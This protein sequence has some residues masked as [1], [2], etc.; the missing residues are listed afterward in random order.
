MRIT[1][2][3]GIL[4]A[5]GWI[6]IKLSLFGMGM[7]SE[8]SLKPAILLNMLFLILAITVGLFLQKRKDSEDGNALRDIKNGMTAGVPYAIIVSVFIYFYYSKIDPEYIQSKL[9]DTEIEL[10]KSMEDPIKFKTLKDSN[11]DFEVM[12]D[13][14]I[15]KSVIK[16]S[17]GVYN[18]KSTAITSLLAMT[19]YATL[20][21]IFITII[22][23]KIVFRR[24]N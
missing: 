8:D 7:N 10:K 12:T 14:Q 19:L 13:K 24:K 16:N 18:A 5:F 21:S 1:L 15:I 22:L 20:N 3:S 4:F 11:P 9:A 17:K 6:L 2:K 23:R